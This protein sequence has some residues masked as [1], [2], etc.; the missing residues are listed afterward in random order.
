MRIKKEFLRFRTAP[1]DDAGQKI[2]PEQQPVQKVMEIDAPASMRG[3]PA[4]GSIPTQVIQEMSVGELASAM[5]KPCFSCKHFDRRAWKLLVARW[6]SPNSPVEERQY[7]NMVRAGLLQTKNADIVSK[8]TGTDG[9]MDVEHALLMLGI[10][11]TLTEVQNAPIIVHPTGA[12]PAEVCT[13]TQPDGFYQ[14]KTTKAERMGSQT[15]DNI[16]RTAQ[17]KT[18]AP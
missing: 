2:E 13:P 14:P 12:C 6:N 15:Y 17:G 1:Y 10:C 16:I 7:L 5:R 8:S 3:G 11:R 4:V 9:D 18:I